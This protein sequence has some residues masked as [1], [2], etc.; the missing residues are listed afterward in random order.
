[1]TSIAFKIYV[2]LIFDGWLLLAFTE[3][4]GMNEWNWLR[5]FDQIVLENDGESQEGEEAQNIGYRCQ[6]DAR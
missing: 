5:R 2:S 1:M 3:I 6:N 4:G